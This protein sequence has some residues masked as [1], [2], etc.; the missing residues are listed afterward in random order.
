MVC[1]GA[2]SEDMAI[3]AC[4]YSCSKIKERK[5]QNKKRRSHYCPKYRSSHQLRWKN[6]SRKAAR[7]LPRS[8]YEPEQ[9]PGLIHRMLDQRQ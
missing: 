1:T 7:T 2:K 4:E 9:F 5:S 3:K 6:S 8:M